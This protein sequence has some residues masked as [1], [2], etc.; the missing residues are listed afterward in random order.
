M[1]ANVAVSLQSFRRLVSA[2]LPSRQGL[3]HTVYT[4]F[5]DKNKDYK[6]LGNDPH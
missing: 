2:D 4:K 1:G 6:L 3:G 5:L